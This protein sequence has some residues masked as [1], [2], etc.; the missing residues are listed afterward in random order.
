VAYAALSPRTDLD[1]L[2]EFA[3]SSTTSLVTFDAFDRVAR[4]CTT[5]T[6][7]GVGSGFAVLCG[8]AISERAHR[9]GDEKLRA[10]GHEVLEISMSQMIRFAGNILELTP[11]SG[12]RHRHVDRCLE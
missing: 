6:S 11:A 8:E 10:T 1:V 3:H 5:P 12:A 9:G 4:P 2:G 7:D